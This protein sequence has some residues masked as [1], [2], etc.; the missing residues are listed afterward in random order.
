MQDLFGRRYVVPSRVR[1]RELYQNVASDGNGII[2]ATLLSKRS[3]TNQVTV[4]VRLINLQTERP[5]AS[6][7]PTR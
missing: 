6:C 7:L 3:Y 5:V 2:H 4:L 1:L